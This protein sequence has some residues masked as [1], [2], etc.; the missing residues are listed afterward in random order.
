MY[1]GAASHV[2]QGRRVRVPPCKVARRTHDHR[3]RQSGEGSCRV[4]LSRGRVAAEHYADIRHYL[5]AE[6]LYTG[7]IRS[8]KVRFRQSFYAKRD[9]ISFA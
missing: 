3:Q 4:P 7:V 2:R 8:N 6:L 1:I 5:T 9:L